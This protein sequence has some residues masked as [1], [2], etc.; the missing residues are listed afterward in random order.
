MTLRGRIRFEAACFRAWIRAS[1]QDPVI[2][3][4]W[5]VAVTCILVGVIGLTIDLCGP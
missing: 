1:G 5:A 2:V 4:L 3:V